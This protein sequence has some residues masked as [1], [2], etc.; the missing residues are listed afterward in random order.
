MA[1]DGS[2]RLQE[3]L[4]GVMAGLGALDRRVELLEDRLANL[5]DDDK[6][7]NVQRG[8]DGLI[9]ALKDVADLHS[10]DPSEQDEAARHALADEV[11]AM[12]DGLRRAMEDL[13]TAVR[14][15]LAHIPDALADHR[16][17]LVAELK[18]AIAAMVMQ[19]PPSAPRGEPLDLGE[20]NLPAP[21]GDVA[22]PE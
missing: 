10:A 8:V 18:A 15:E 2:D 11:Q 17:A 16:T 22:E 1:P 6:L 12:A 4:D 5:P 13:S 14:L 21:G 3:S 20:I 19:S 9:Q 7:A